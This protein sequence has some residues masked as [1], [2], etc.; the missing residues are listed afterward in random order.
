M[1][2]LIEIFA[3]LL[4]WPLETEINE[5]TQ[6]CTF[7]IVVCMRFLSQTSVNVIIYTNP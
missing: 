7:V 6:V 5:V 4:L 3:F 1:F 2:I